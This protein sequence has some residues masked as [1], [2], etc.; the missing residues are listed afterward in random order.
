MPMQASV[1]EFVKRTISTDGT[2]SHTILARTF[3]F[4]DGAPKDVPFSRAFTRASLTSS[5]AWPQI[6]GPQVPT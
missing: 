6:A 2:A 3:S 4:S 5:F 1:P